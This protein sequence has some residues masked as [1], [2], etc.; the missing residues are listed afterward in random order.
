MP[1]SPD[2]QNI[3][4]VITFQN[5]GNLTSPNPTLVIPAGLTDLYLTTIRNNL[6]TSLLLAP[7][8]Q[9]IVKT[10][11]ATNQVTIIET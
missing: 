3:V 9:Q 1:I 4:D 10:L 8:V 7:D 6:S 2:T 5:L 11:I